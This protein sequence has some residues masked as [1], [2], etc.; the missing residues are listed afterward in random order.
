MSDNPRA[1]ARIVA[2]I[3]ALLGG[4][5]AALLWRSFELGE[6][7]SY[8]ALLYGRSLWGVAH[9][10]PLNTAYGTHWFGIHAN[11]VFLALA[12]LVW[13]VHPA[14]VLVACQAAAFAAT[15][16]LVAAAARRAVAVAG[17]E[18]A[19]LSGAATVWAVVAVAVSPLIMNPFLFDARPELIGVPLLVAALLRADRDRGFDRVGYLL[20]VAAALTREELGVIGA[21]AV[22][23]APIRWRRR[24]AAARLLVP[25]SLLAW[26]AVYWWFVRP[27]LAGGDAGV[28]ADLATAELFGGTGEGLAGARAQLALAAAAVGGGFAVLGWRWAAAVL[29]GLAFVLAATKLPEYALNFHY[30]FL[31]APGLV[32]AATSGLRRW[33]ER[34]A[35]GGRAVLL[36][37]TLVGAGMY[38]W[39]GAAPG[40]GRFSAEHFAFDP[41]AAAWQADCHALLDVIPSEGGVAVPSMFGTMFSDRPVVYSTETLHAALSELG[42]APDDLEWAAIDSPRFSSIGRFLVTRSGFRLVGIASGRIALL[43]RRATPQEAPPVLRSPDATTRCTNLQAAWP[44]AGIGVC[45]L[46]VIDGIVVGAVT[47]T[48]PPRETPAPAVAIVAELERGSTQLDA[49]A[50]LV[51]PATLPVGVS[52]AIRSADRVRI[53]DLR[54]RLYDVTGREYRGVAYS[55]AAAGEPALGVALSLPFTESAPND[56]DASTRY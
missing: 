40:G 36:F 41:D 18:R 7:Q 24:E 39:L 43:R 22:L 32:V 11:V 46:A 56:T 54:L 13:I 14:R 38:A 44:D 16:A 34:G 9:G 47:R 35:R 52:V 5:V 25:A 33:L 27:A 17:P 49:F 42:R 6:S 45:D 48:S 31:A 12:P 10:A 19:A 2:V 26:F 55:G 8:D 21:V 53:G 37:S 30:P 3:A 1:T 20:V 50:G 15:A 51:D 4:V 29:P 28:R 23:G